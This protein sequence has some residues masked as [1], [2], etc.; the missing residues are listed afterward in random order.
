MTMKVNVLV[1]CNN[2]QQNMLISCGRGDKTFKWLGMVASQRYAQSI[3]NGSLRR[4]DTDSM[5]SSSSRT[6][7]LPESMLLPDGEY[8]H[9]SELLTDYI[10]DGDTVTCILSNQL[11]V[12]KLSS[13]NGTKWATMAFTASAD[14]SQ[15][16]E[17]KEE[18]KPP[19]EELRIQKMNA[20]FMRVV[21][22]SQ[23]ID[24][25][26]IARALD[27]VWEIVPRVMPRLSV[28][29]SSALKAI[30][31]DYFSMLQSLF[32]HYASV[33]SGRMDLLTFTTVMEESETFFQK[34]T[35]K[36]SSK[37]YER[38]ISM[39]GESS[40]DFGLFIACLVLCAQ[41]RHND[42]LDQNTALKD[43]CG[44]LRPLLSQ[45]ML[46]LTNKLN[47]PCLV[48]AE[49]CAE[50]NLSFMRQYHGEIF[51]TFESY[52]NV[53]LRDLPLTITTEQ[54]A[55]VLFDAGLIESASNIKIAENILQDTRKGLIKGRSVYYDPDDPNDADRFPDDEYTFS[56]FF[57]G[58]QRAGIIYYA[59]GDNF[60]SGEIEGDD[61]SSHQ[62]P[63]SM[64][65]SMLQGLEDVV[66]ARNR[67]PAPS[68]SKSSNKHRK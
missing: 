31:S 12:T 16:F 52:A 4:R 5:R 61:M 39:S 64:I 37:V 28:E 21:L 35:E 60:P 54:M 34:D 24:D 18:E 2:E 17:E 27:E 30:C 42:T 10:E 11:P 7:R 59:N 6:Q 33:S 63:L 57:E 43:P 13:P 66:A 47:L 20:S 3:P 53:L 23:M 38:I 56:E 8:A 15:N 1:K 14:Q 9:P 51:L 29:F 67:K 48:R 49:L 62:E 40:L 46:F 26:K 65:E 41:T 58:I 36:L 22:E 50:E 19:L 45:N 25:K 68:P 32:A 44:A 55:E